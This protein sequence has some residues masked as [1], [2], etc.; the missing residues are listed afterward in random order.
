MPVHEDPAADADF[1]VLERALNW[2]AAGPWPWKTMATSL[3][4]HSV[5]ISLFTYTLHTGT[6]HRQAPTAP[7]RFVQVFMP[8]PSSVPPAPQQVHMP[9]LGLREPPQL[10]LPGPDAPKVAVNFNSINL[11]FALDVGNQLPAV[12]E[13]QHGMLALL[14]KEDHGLARYLMRPPGWEPRATIT[15]VSR[16]LRFMMTPPRKWPVFREAEDRYGI[17]L[18]RYVAAA[19]FDSSYRRCLDLAIRRHL[20]PGTSGRVSAARLAFAMSGDCGII[21]QEVTFAPTPEP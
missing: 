9:T 8:R 17:D 10:E 1:L 7:E 6:D 11:S 12:V 13:Q 14:D 20:S 2:R 15:D 19:V 3:I 16:D 18:D 4:L 21:V 5:A